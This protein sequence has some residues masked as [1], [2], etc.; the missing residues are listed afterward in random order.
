MNSSTMTDRYTQSNLMSL[1]HGL[2]YPLSW[3][4]SLLKSSHKFRQTTIQ[5]CTQRHAYIVTYIHTVT[6]TYTQIQSHLHTPA[7]THL[8][9][10][11]MCTGFPSDTYRYICTEKK[12]GQVKNRSHMCTQFYQKE[13]NSSPLTQTRHTHQHRYL[14]IYTPIYIYTVI[15]CTDVQ[16]L[17]HTCT[18]IDF[19]SF[20]HTHTHTH[21]HA[22]TV[23][24][25]KYN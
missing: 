3:Y 4:S 9:P 2:I 11:G 10:P 23:A 21:M 12:N 17:Q 24:K 8:L 6:H 5:I 20:T 7:N 25:C 1:T 16:Q 15:H 22:H 18:R 19:L 14:H 13:T